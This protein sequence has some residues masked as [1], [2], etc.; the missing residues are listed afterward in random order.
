MTLNFTNNAI[1]ILTIFFFTFSEKVFS[2]DRLCKSLDFAPGGICLAEKYDPKTK[3]F[4]TC[5]FEILKMDE[6]QYRSKYDPCFGGKNYGLMII[7]REDRIIINKIVSDYMKHESYVRW[8]IFKSTGLNF[9]DKFFL[10][11]LKTK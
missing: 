4:E 10:H 2:E 6:D 9:F 11:S 5:M 7:S 3:A 8:M 1:W